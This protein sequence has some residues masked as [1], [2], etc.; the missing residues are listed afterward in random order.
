[1]YYWL[2]NSIAWLLSIL[3]FYEQSRANS[4]PATLVLNTAWLSLTS[5]FIIAHLATAGLYPWV[6]Y[7]W[8]HFFFSLQGWRSGYISFGAVL[9]AI[10]SFYL[11]SRLHH[12]SFTRI[13]D[14]AAPCV[15][16]GSAIGRIGCFFSGCCYGAPSSLPW[17]VRFNES[18]VECHPV[19]LYES[20]LS[21]LFFL[22]LPLLRRI[23]FTETGNG[24]FICGCL[25][26]YFFE[27]IFLEIFR[28]GGSSHVVF[29]G[30]SRI[31][32]AGLSGSLI[33]VSYILIKVRKLRMHR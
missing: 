2:F 32:I 20:F 18:Q 7:N 17:A 22:F 24:I 33:C 1:M 4:M 23:P 27:R 31:S 5:S 28:L 21:L 19:Q 30:L 16:I 9:G 26:I 12:I 6:L 29:M 10:L 14:I 15:F 3:Y 11:V 25:T 8:D 13:A